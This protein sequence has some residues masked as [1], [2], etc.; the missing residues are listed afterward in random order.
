[1]KIIRTLKLTSDEFY[2]YLE[3]ELLEIANQ[4]CT[5]GTAYT[6]ED[7]NP[8]FKVT[9][10]IKEAHQGVDLT[11]TEYIRGCHY[12]AAIT[13]LSGTTHL[14]YSTRQTDTGLETTFEQEM[15]NSVQKKKS[16][17]FRGFS[18]AIYLSRM[19]N[20]LYDMQNK[21]IKD[22]KNCRLCD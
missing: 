12:K 17:L 5:R 1:M 10:G 3:N 22:R 14:S 13:S 9:R 20:S 7:I 11:I 8:G 19:S 15:P 2:D 21:I 16:R 18:D 4:N 6:P